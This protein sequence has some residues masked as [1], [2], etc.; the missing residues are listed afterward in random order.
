MSVLL[1]AFIIASAI[2]ALVPGCAL[3]ALTITVLPPAKADAVSP[4]AVE[5]A[6][7]KLLAANTATGPKGTNILLRSGL[8]IGD[9][10]ESPFSITASTQDPSS[11]KS[12][13]IRS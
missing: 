6:R 10:F 13:N 2:R 9:L 1:A 5:N 7:G 8:G 4:P 11:I 12:A 3:C